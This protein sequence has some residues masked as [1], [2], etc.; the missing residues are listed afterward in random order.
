MWQQTPSV[1]TETAG[2]TE[3]PTFDS[4]LYNNKQEKN[5]FA[6]VNDRV[7]LV[8]TPSSSR[9]DGR[10]CRL[11]FYSTVSG[12]AQ[13]ASVGSYLPLTRFHLPPLYAR[14]IVYLIF[15]VMLFVRSHSLPSL[16]YS[17]RG[18]TWC[19]TQQQNNRSLS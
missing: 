3:R 2:E 11:F 7:K 10:C 19:V 17:I 16:Q 14:H 4:Y 9:W 18:N 15:H 13:A 5:L 6:D 1:E 8:L 12:I